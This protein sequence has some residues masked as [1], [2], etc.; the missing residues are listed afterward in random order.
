MNHAAPSSRLPSLDGWRAVSI[1]MVLGYHAAMASP[2]S[3]SPVF[4]MFFDGNLGVRF[5]FVISGFLIT[6]LLLKESK[7]TGKVSLNNFYVRRFLRIF[8]VYFVYVLVLF[9]LQLFAK[10]KETPAG[11]LGMLTFTRNFTDGL[12]ANGSMGSAHLWSL[13]VEEQ[14]YLL[15]PG[16]Y[17]LVCHRSFRL[18]AALLAIPIITAPIFRIG[19]Y[20]FLMDHTRVLQGADA[21]HTPPRLVGAYG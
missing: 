8:P 3:E 7:Q 17:V 19:T 18:K 1:I 16:L 20:I 5:F 11:W 21:L 15:W 12:T 6:W 4:S 9:G 14:F 2:D 10:F 13:S